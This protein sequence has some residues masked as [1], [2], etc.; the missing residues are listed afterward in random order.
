MPTENRETELPEKGQLGLKRLEREPWKPE[1]RSGILNA[2]HDTL[3]HQLELV[4]ESIRRYDLMQRRQK[5]ETRAEVEAQLRKVD[6]GIAELEKVIA[7]DEASQNPQTPARPGASVSK[8]ADYEST[9]WK[10]AEIAKRCALQSIW[11]AYG[12][13]TRVIRSATMCLLCQISSNGAYHTSVDG[14]ELTTGLY[15]SVTPL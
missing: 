15:S 4:G 10:A 12:L 3:R 1:L 5:T 13:A 14:W 11:L 6:E 8:K 9:G 2:L 7:R